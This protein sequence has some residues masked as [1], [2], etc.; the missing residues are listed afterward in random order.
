[1]V[2]AAMVETRG[3]AR[4]DARMV[5]LRI[6]AA[7]EHIAL[8]RLALSGLAELTAMTEETLS[9][10]K[11][12]LSEAVSNSIRGADGRTGAYV[13][14]CFSLSET[15]I[16][17]EVVGDGCDVGFS[18]PLAGELGVESRARGS[19]VRFVTHLRSE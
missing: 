9:G 12:A 2:E 11:L 13:E 14:V 1:M 18:R 17:I 19:R 16:G 7:A 6:P 4:D 5:R 8:P 15:A 10:L 3:G